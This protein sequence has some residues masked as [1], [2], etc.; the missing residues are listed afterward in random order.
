M[1]VLLALAVLATSASALASSRDIY[2]IMYLP[3][4]GTTYGSTFLSQVDGRVE[5]TPDVDIDGFTITQAVGHSFTDRFLVEASLNY[6]KT[7]TDVDYGP[8]TES[9]GFSDPT[10]S[11]RFRVMD[12][13]LRLD[14]I[15]GALISI[16]DAKEESDGDTNNLN[17]GSQLF[18]GAQV[19]Q[20][21]SS[22][23]WSFLGQINHAMKAKTNVSG[24]SDVEDDA[25][26]T[27]TFRADLL[28]KLTDSTFIRTHLSSAFS[29]EYDDDN[30]GSTSS[31]TTYE[32]GA[33]FQHMFTK[34]FLGRLGVDYRRYNTGL[35]NVDSFDLWAF[36]IGAL[37]QF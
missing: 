25:F 23:Q 21:E 33:E 27:L 22:Y 36:N 19:G 31:L 16:G 4:A 30:N 6:A 3:N 18:A 8:R 11:G 5:A 2:D 15:G 1:K 37:Y 28:N 32:I 34:D 12:E 17:G 14:I 9:T 29:E 13:S 7:G 35:A 10:V 24:G 26:N 20:K